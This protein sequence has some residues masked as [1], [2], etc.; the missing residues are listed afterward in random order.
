MLIA[1]LFTLYTLSQPRAVITSYHLSYQSTLSSVYGLG[2]NKQL[3][4]FHLK[5]SLTDRLSY[6]T[7]EKRLKERKKD[8]GYYYFFFIY[9]FFF[10]LE[11]NQVEYITFSGLACFG[12]CIISA[13]AFSICLFRIWTAFSFQFKVLKNYN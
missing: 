13:A 11:I 9:L 10:A 1:I 8:Q 4:V 6:Q 5:W 12:F 2:P 3:I 7:K